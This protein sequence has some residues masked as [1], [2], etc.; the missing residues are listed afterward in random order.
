[1][2]QND[3]FCL[4]I[5]LIKVAHSYTSY[6]P[7]FPGCGGARVRQTDGFGLSRGGWVMGDASRFGGPR[8]LLEVRIFFCSITFT[9]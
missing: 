8:H 6:A 4:P 5:R 1:M 9:K 2:S 7:E 3:C